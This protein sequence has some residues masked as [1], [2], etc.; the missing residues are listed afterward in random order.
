MLKLTIL[1]LLTCAPITFAAPAALP[2]QAGAQA[3]AKNDAPDKRPEVA[4]LI[5]KLDK[6]V[7]KRGSEDTDAVA[8]IAQLATEFPKSGP[9][10]KTAIANALSKCVEAQRAEPK[11]GEFNNKLAIAAAEAMGQMGPESVQPLIGW[12]GHKNL[13]RDIQLQRQLVLS[14]GKTRDPAAIKPLNSALENKDAPIVAAAAEAMGEFSEAKIEVRKDLFSSCIKALM[15]GKN[16][17]D[18]EQSGSGATAH[19]NIA[20]ERYDVIAAPLLTTLHKLSKHEESTPEL[21]ERWWNKNRQVNW[22]S[23]KP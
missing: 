5:D 18:A 20:T 10:D 8:V 21:W 2:I 16:A 11:K 3:G 15:A 1:A 22:D 9:K 14:L 17:K 19:T 13:R 4:S 23:G 7:D 6:H 12:I